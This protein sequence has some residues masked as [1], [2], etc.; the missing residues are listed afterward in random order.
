MARGTWG[1][2]GDIHPLKVR[3][4][5]M[6][7]TSQ[8]QTGF[9]LRDSSLT[10]SNPQ[11]CANEVADW[12][13]DD[14]RN[15]FTVRDRFLGVDVVDL[16]TGEGGAVSFGNLVGTQNIS[17]ANTPPSYVQVPYS[18]KGELRR[19]YGQGR[20]LIPVRNEAW[21]DEDKLNPTGVIS[22]QSVI[23]TMVTRYL[24]TG[25]STDYTLINVH[26]IIPPKLATPTTP[27]RPQVEPSWYDVTTIRLNSVLSFVRSR[28]AG[29]GS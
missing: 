5:F 3:I 24:G 18:L 25:G 8:C 22:L 28:K 26:G 16:T 21:M 7:G 2:S 14:F 11:S 27:A 4:A 9:T 19:R 13:T 17:E 6:L 29:V 20:M 23:D 1:G 15:I 10:P 12:V